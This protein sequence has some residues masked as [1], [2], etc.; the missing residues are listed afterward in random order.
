MQRVKIKVMDPVVWS[1]KQKT[2]AVELLGGRVVGL[3]AHGHWRD[4]SKYENPIFG[5]EFTV[6]I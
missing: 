5:C 2:A 3:E 4:C 6:A 1:V